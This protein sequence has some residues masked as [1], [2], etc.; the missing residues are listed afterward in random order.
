MKIKLFWLV[1]AVWEQREVLTL[2]LNLKEP[3]PIVKNEE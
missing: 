2:D 3:L 1:K